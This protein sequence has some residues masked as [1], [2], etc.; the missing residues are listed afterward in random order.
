[1]AIPAADLKKNRVLLGLSGGVDST[2]AAFLLQERGYEVIGFFFDVLG[3]RN[4]ASSAEAAANAL[5]IDFIYKN[6]AEEFKKIIIDHFC[7]EYIGGRTPNPC[8]NCNPLIKFKLMLEAA[9]QRGAYH[10]ATGHYARVRYVDAISRYA[11]FKGASALKDQS[12]MLYALGQDVLSRVL[13]PLGDIKEKEEVRK[14]LRAEN[15]RNSEAKDSQEIC[16]I[17]DN[18]YVKFIK[19]Q[20]WNSAGGRFVDKKG[21]TLGTHQGVMNYTVG[22]RKGL[23]VTFGKPKYVIKLN[24][25]DNTV[26][27]GD[28]SDLFSIEVY[29]RC[30]LDN[31]AIADTSELRAGLEIKAKIRYAAKEAPAVI[32]LV[33][34][35]AVGNSGATIRSVF[36]EPQRA[37][38]PGQSIVFYIDDMLLGGGVIEYAVPR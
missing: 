24:A 4:Q 7:A 21:N 11:V 23:G 38:T 31:F 26:V 15:I 22:Q 34:V 27:L 18:D 1:M 20:E 30:N 8:V 14:L 25:E 17:K 5:G 29:S 2:A 9:D 35:N 16:F 3:D 12:Y 36:K 13:F 33:E 32:S 37:A 19:A 28:E 10:I 6:A